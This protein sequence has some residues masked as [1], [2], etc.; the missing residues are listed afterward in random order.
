LQAR[1][2]LLES[3]ILRRV[4][5]HDGVHL[6]G[7]V[8]EYHDRVRD[9]Q[10]NVGH[11]QRVWVRAGPQALF[12]I[13]HTVVAEVTDQAAIETWQAGNVGDLVA[14]LERLDKGQRVFDIVAFNLD[15]VLQDAD[16]IAVHPH[17][18]PRGQADHRV[19][20]RGMRL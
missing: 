13:A 19:T 6:A 2:A 20:A 9:H 8:V 1:L 3:L 16:V 12:H 5:Q 18:R 14:F 4:Y 10:Q 17:H 11:A 7:Q 15:T